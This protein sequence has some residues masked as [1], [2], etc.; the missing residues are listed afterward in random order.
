MGLDVCCELSGGGG[1]FI[2]C[3]LKPLARYHVG[4]GVFIL[5]WQA[6]CYSLG[7]IFSVL[8]SSGLCP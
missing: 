3:S 6:G 8:D 2:K 5:T 7:L 1:R 4:T